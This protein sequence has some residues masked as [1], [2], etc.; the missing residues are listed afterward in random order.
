MNNNNNMFKTNS[1]FDILSEKEEGSTKL[2]NQKNKG[3]QLLSKFGYS[4]G[5]GLG[6]DSQGIKEPIAQ[7]KNHFRAGVGIYDTDK[8][9][10]FKKTQDDELKR[11]MLSIDN[12]PEFSKNAMEKESPSWK[13]IDTAC[14]VKQDINEEQ[15]IPYG[16]ALLT[17]D[18]KT[19]RLYKK[20]NAH[21]LEDILLQ[22]QE[23]IEMRPVIVLDALVQLHTK[24]TEQYIQNWGY[25]EYEQMF[26]SP[27]YDP[28][29]FDKLDAKE[30]EEEKQNEQ[31]E[32]SMNN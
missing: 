32:F 17:R 20:Y 10:H 22:E 28:Y 4:P 27:Y 25:E 29:Y 12:F 16:W 11:Q 24:R 23:E 3:Y 7:Q 21:Y 8:I 6:K 5:I 15:V 19:R 31:G 13:Y 26:I 2:I 9:N 30:E 18:K 1:R 14:P